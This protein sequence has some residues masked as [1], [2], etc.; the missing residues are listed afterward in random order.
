MLETHTKYSLNI[1]APGEII[2]INTMNPTIL[3]SN[4]AMLVHIRIGA[5]LSR[6]SPPMFPPPS[7]S[8]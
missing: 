5:S 6:T 4:L 8:K 2:D 1:Q 7:H 3:D